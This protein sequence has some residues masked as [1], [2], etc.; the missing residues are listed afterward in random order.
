MKKPTKASI[1][2]KR[3]QL[4]KSLTNQEKRTF[5]E[6]GSEERD[7]QEKII[8]EILELR[9]ELRYHFPSYTKDLLK[10]DNDDLRN[11]LDRL[12]NRKKEKNYYN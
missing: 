12:H 8:K 6:K 9:K 5:Y 2:R 4:I 1:K 3:K 7:T 10:Y 11:H